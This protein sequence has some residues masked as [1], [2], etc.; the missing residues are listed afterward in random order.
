MKK[1]LAAVLTLVFLISGALFAAEKV[2]TLRTS[3]NLAE[4]STV[5]KGLKYFVEQINAQSKGRI[6]ATANYGAELGNQAE[7][8]AMTLTKDLEMVVAA[9]GTGPGAYKGLEP[10]MM[11]EFPFMFKDNNHYRRV[12]KAAEPKVNEFVKA[13]GFTAMAG[14]SQGSRDILTSKP[15]TKLADMQK[16]VMRG[17]NA[18]YISMFEHLGASGVTM[19]WNEIYTALSQKVVDGAEGSPSSLNASK[20]QDNAKNLAITNHI[21][22]CIYYFFN[23]EW[24]ESLPDDLQQLVRK[25]A[26]E[27]TA[28]QEK[29]DDDD[30][31]KA[32]EQMKKDGVIVTEIKDIDEWKKACAPMLDEYR[33]KGQNWSDFIDYLSKID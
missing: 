22:A 24:F 19:D 21:I 29:L 4:G 6:K 30:Q 3:T 27:A 33:K 14:Q 10:L 25:V 17:P 31:G 20:F 15:V 12:L 18:I 5:G 1:T 32:L 13:K 26:A 11:F 8:V 2:Y 9:P 23:T 7:Q 28:Y 16:L